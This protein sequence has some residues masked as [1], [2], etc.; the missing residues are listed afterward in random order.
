MFDCLQLNALYFCR[1]GA[2][3]TSGML[4]AVSAVSFY[5]CR[6]M[7]S[8]ELLLLGRLLVGLASGLATAT[9]PMY[10]AECAPLELRGTFAVLLSMG[11]PQCL[12]WVCFSRSLSPS[13]Q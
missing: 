6:G 2:L 12:I 4:F 8:V 5:M 3:L 10:M 11:E 9:V 13:P 7:H 1:K